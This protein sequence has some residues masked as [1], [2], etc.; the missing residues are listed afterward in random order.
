MKTI[1]IIIAGAGIAYVLYKR[2]TGKSPLAG[3]AVAGTILDPA[4]WPISKP[5]SPPEGA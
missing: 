5:P 4:S 1:L 2:H 3:T